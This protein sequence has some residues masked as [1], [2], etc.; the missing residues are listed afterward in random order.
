MLTC[1]SLLVTADKTSGTLANNFPLAPYDGMLK[2]E[3]VQWHTINEKFGNSNVHK[4]WIHTYIPALDWSSVTDRERDYS[5]PL[6][7]ESVCA[8]GPVASLRTE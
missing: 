7:P 8:M 1:S 4:Q 6:R 5:D 3:I 2:E